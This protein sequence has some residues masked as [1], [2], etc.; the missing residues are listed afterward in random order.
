LEQAR[1][2]LEEARQAMQQGDWTRFG[3][4]MQALER[5]LTGSPT[6]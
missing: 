5:D 6:R 4:A 2:L 3:T 1:T